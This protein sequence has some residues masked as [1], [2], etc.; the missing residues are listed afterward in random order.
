MQEG[1]TLLVLVAG[2]LD[3]RVGAGWR[4]QEGGGGTLRAQM[5]PLH[6][7]CTLVPMTAW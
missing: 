4:G 7:L 6:S 3:E 1:E 2:V 5:A